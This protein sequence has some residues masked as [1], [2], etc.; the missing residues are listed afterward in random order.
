M[1]KNLN[2]APNHPKMVA[3]VN[4]WAEL[5]EPGRHLLV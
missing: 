2:A 3:W 4:E 5:C 1:V